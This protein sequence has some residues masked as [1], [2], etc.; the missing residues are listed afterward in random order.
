[1]VEF[2]VVNMVISTRLPDSGED[3]QQCHTSG[4]SRAGHDKGLNPTAGGAQYNGQPFEYCR[5]AE[6]ENGI[7]L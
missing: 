6:Q 5:I 1:M 4:K 2:S 7:F 3:A